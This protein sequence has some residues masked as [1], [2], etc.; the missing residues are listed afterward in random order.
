VQAEDA[1][2]P[3]NL[4]IGEAGGDSEDLADRLDKLLDDSP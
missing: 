4:S 1:P 2:S 3:D